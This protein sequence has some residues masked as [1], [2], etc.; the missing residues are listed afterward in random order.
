MN[1]EIKWMSAQEIYSYLEEYEFGTELGRLYVMSLFWK[2]ALYPEIYEANKEW[3]EILVL[4]DYGRSIYE[5]INSKHKVTSESDL[6][7]ILFK[8]FSY[9]H[10]LFDQ[11]ATD[12]DAV[13]E[14]LKS[15]LQDEKIFLPFRFGRLL[16]DRFNDNY[17]GKGTDHLT[18]QEVMNLISGTPK[19]VYQL[20]KYLT[21]P[22]GLIY[23]IESRYLPPSP[24]LP[25]WH[26]SD[27]GCFTPHQVEFLPPDVPLTKLD[28]IAKHILQEKLGPPSD[29]HWVIRQKYLAR[30]DYEEKPLAYCDTAVFIADSIIGNERTLL[31]THSLKRDIGRELRSILSS[32]PRRKN[33]GEGKAELIASSL[34]PE[35]QL[36]LIL[37]LP[38][39]FTVDLI[40]EL[41]ET[42]WLSLPFGQR[43]RAKNTPPFTSSLN[44]TCELSKL[45]MR[46]TEEAPI[47]ILVSFIYSAYMEQGL[48]GDLQWRLK[49]SVGIPLKEALVG[50]VRE[51]GPKIAIQELV[52]SSP[53]I[54]KF[55]CNKIRLSL[56]RITLKTEETV[57]RVL[58]KIGF[59]PPQYNDFCR[60]FIS[61]LERFNQVLL[62]VPS[63]EKED[64]RE[65][66]RAAGVNLFVYSLIAIAPKISYNLLK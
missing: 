26:C 28:H 50:Y 3:P 62:S 1:R 39:A 54:T 25:L 38:D 66:I 47:V 22:L 16:Y 30:R 53:N 56:D 27:T 41:T 64:E 6:I 51:K 58:W 14:V 24:Y 35:E 45:G 12:I 33:A 44:I 57:D 55:I 23:S 2:N 46:S 19:G 21:G 61:H 11:T 65:A 49:S 59:N 63:L 60:R 36:Q 40:D 7:F 18:N 37:V 29:W 13:E 52:L 17:I 42:G 15:E 10:I 8:I 4:S 20:D 34:S 9:H 31:L 32:P 5:L 43:R 48:Q